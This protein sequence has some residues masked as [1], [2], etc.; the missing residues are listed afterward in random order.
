M[1]KFDALMYLKNRKETWKT[2][3]KLVTKRLK[4]TNIS[5]LHVDGNSFIDPVGIANSMNQY[6]CNVGDELCKDIPDTDNGLLLGE[7]A[8]N[9]SNATVIFTPVL[10][11][12]VAL[13][14]NRF[15]TSNGFGL[16]Q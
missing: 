14:I 5:S 7:Y 8:I 6:F 11:K 16:H 15:N 10:S 13:A 3:N 1:E 4:A 2:I 12:Q 9:T